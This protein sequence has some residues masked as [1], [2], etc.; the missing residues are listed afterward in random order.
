M[1]VPSFRIAISIR[2]LAVASSFHPAVDQL[3]K[4]EQN[5]GNMETKSHTY[6]PYADRSSATDYPPTS[7]PSDVQCQEAKG[8]RYTGLLPRH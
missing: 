4:E 1:C 8:C 2:L 3:K 6:N 7:L 5:R